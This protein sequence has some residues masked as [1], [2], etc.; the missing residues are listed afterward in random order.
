MQVDSNKDILDK[1]F[2]QIRLDLIK[3]YDELGMRA[4]GKTDT[5]II[6]YDRGEIVLGNKKLGYD[7][8]DLRKKN[9]EIN[10]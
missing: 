7:I 1:E 4:S 10:N 9:L 5:A 2:E 8:Y 6:T 3:R